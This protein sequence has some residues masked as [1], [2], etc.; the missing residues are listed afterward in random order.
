MVLQLVN[1]PAE[2][3]ASYGPK[4]TFLSLKGV[5]SPGRETD[6]H[7]DKTKE[8]EKPALQRVQ[9]VKLVFMLL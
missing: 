5:Y 6:M 7:T 2:T 1:S 8:W 4:Q 3:E 9:K